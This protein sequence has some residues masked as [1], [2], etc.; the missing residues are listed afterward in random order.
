MATQEPTLLPLELNPKLRKGTTE[1][2]C[3]QSQFLQ[4]LVVLLPGKLN[5]LVLV[6]R[7]LQWNQQHQI[8]VF[9][10]NQF[11]NYIIS[12][13]TVHHYLDNVS[14]PFVWSQMTEQELKF[15]R[16]LMKNNYEDFSLTLEKN[17]R[18]SKR[19]KKQ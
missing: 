18:T 16:Y 14:M 3:S 5:E 1:L 9:Q 10:K 11:I 2:L 6:R 12:P 15:D 4:P 8:R 13:T 19:R 7:N 17:Q